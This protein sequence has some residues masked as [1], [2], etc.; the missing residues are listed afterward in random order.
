MHGDAA[1]AEELRN[2]IGEVVAVVLEKIVGF[3]A[4]DRLEGIEIFEEYLIRE[5]GEAERNNL[6]GSAVVGLS[7]TGELNS[8]SCGQSVG[9]LVGST[10][11]VSDVP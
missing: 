10:Y 6:H 5:R 8:L 2:V 11:M 4:V 9:C 1:A 7:G 3:V